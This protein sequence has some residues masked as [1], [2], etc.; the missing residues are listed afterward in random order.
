[1]STSHEFCGSSVFLLHGFLIW[2]LIVQD[3]FVICKLKIRPD[4]KKIITKKS[5]QAEADC[6]NTSPK[7]KA[8]KANELDNNRASNENIVETFTNLHN[9]HS[10]KQTDTPSHEVTAMAS[11]KGVAMASFVNQTTT[12]PTCNEED[13]YLKKQNSE[14]GCGKT[15]DLGKV[16]AVNQNECHKT[17]LDC[18]SSLKMES[19]C[20]ILDVDFDVL[21]GYSIDEVEFRPM[22]LGT[23]YPTAR[24]NPS[25]ETPLDFDK[26]D[27]PKISDIPPKTAHKYRRMPS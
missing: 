7:K 11:N 24:P 13:C 8:R 27:G 20:K 3:K 25:M 6:K 19:Q 1:M 21:M 14:Y 18:K 26:T 9:E 2:Y 17:D 23:Q 15:G 22:D 12:V 10:N 4:R 5:K 16:V